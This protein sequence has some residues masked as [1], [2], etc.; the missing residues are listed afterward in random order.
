MALQANNLLD[1]ADASA[2]TQAAR[3]YHRLTQVLRLCLEGPY[4]PTTAIPGLNRA[5]ARA[6]ELPDVRMAEAQL[7]E[8]EAHVARLFDKLVGSPE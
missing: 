8:H 4:E 1:A 2:L 7:A 6:A 3:L 5:I